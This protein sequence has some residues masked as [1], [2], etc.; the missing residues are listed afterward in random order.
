MKIILAEGHIFVWVDNSN[1][2]ENIF[3]NKWDKKKFELIS[4][5]D[6]I[7]KKDWEKL[8]GKQVKLTLEVQDE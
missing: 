4:L 3:V 6:F 8:R 5:V 1:S 7:D 2:I